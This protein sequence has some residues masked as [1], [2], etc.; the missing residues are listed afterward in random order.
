MNIIFD[1]QIVPGGPKISR[2]KF[3]GFL[4]TNW[5]PVI[6]FFFMKQVK[7]CPLDTR[8]HDKFVFSFLFILMIHIV[9]T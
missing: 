5:H 9:S 7:K 2:D 4:S 1:R 8:G 6:H 3:F